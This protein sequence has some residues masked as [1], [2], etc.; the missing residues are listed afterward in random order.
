MRPWN[1]R[2]CIHLSKNKSYTHMCIQH[3]RTNTLWK[4]HAWRLTCF[5]FAGVSIWAMGYKGVW[6]IVNFTWEWNKQGTPIK[7]CFVF[8]SGAIPRGGILSSAGRNSQNRSMLCTL[9][10]DSNLAMWCA[11]HRTCRSTVCNKLTCSIYSLL[12]ERAF[13]LGHITHDNVI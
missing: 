1:G 13:T 9:Q 8:A 11:C 4:I 2:Q 3:I 6:A 5:L 7:C 12:D 10:C